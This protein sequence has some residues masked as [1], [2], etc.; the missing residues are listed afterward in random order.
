M[1]RRKFTISVFAVIVLIVLLFPIVV[2]TVFIDPKVTLINNS[3]DSIKVFIREGKAL[4]VIDIK[5]DNKYEFRPNG[6]HSFG[7]AASTSLHSGACETV[8]NLCCGEAISTCVSNNKLF[9]SFRMRVFL[10]KSPLGNL[11]LDVEK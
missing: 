10:S 11:S 8:N 5:P 4:R 2:Y 7:V 9:S 3:G 1:S 6:D